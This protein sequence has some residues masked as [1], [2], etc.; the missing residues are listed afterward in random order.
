MGKRYILLSLL[1]LFALAIIAPPTTH[2]ATTTPIETAGVAVVIEPNVIVKNGKLYIAYIN[3]THSTYA[4]G[5][6]VLAVYDIASSATR[7]IVIDDSDLAID[8]Y[9]AAGRDSILVVISKFVTGRYRDVYAYLYNITTDKVYGPF[10]IAETPYYDEYPLAAYN[11]AAD[12][13][14][15]AIYTS[16]GPL[17]EFSLRL[18]KFSNN[19]IVLNQAYG[20]FT[21]R[22]GNITYTTASHQLIPYLGGFIYLNPIVNETDTTNRDIEIRYLDAA[23]G[24]I[25]GLRTIVTPGQNE[26]LGDVLF[27]YHPSGARGSAIYRPYGYAVVGDVL[28]VPVYTFGPRNVKLLKISPDLSAEYIVVSEGRDP[29]IHVGAR[30]FAVSYLSLDGAS[31]LAKVFS[32]DTLAEIATVNLS[33]LGGSASQ[34]THFRPLLAFASGYYIAAWSAGNPSSIFAAVFDESGSGIG[35]AEP[36]IR[37]DG[38]YNA[39]LSSLRVFESSVLAVYM[40]QWNATTPLR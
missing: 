24:E 31:A 25:K 30:S 26:S 20:P 16:G 36:I 9:A 35:R 4:E 7:Y 1:A 21:T 34:G 19:N 3:V 23:T 18:L 10:P 39:T 29:Y 37:T 38:S 17:T 2:S 11:P 33:L 12:A 32:S 5:D 8:I 28:L 6:A 22:G 14:A 13:F 40:S 15:I 27:I